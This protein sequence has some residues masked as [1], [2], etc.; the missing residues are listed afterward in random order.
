VGGACATAWRLATPRDRI[1]IFGSFH[2][3]G[4]AMEWLEAQALLPSLALR[5]YTKS[6]PSK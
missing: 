4:P 2:T 5:E 6:L 3:V 1:V